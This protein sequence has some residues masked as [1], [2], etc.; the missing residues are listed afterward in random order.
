MTITELFDLR[1]RLGELSD[2]AFL[3]LTFILHRLD[4]THF[5]DSEGKYIYLVNDNDPRVVFHWSESKFARL[6]SELK[7]YHLIKI[8]KSGTTRPGRVYSTV[9]KYTGQKSEHVKSD[10]SHMTVRN[11]SNSTD[12]TCQ[13]RQTE[14]IKSDMFLLKESKYGKRVW[15]R[16]IE[17]GANAPIPIPSSKESQKSKKTKNDNLDILDIFGGY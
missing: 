13:I 1:G 9:E 16:N 17:K 3:L 8:K 2:G 11:M 5:S 10:M 4:I 7:D 12:G 6:K 14:T 15:K